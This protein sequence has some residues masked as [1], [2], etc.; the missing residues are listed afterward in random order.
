MT[1]QMVFGTSEGQDFQLLND[2]VAL[3]GTGLT[4]SIEWRDPAPTSPPTV[5]WLSAAAGTVRV[6]GT[7]SM[8]VGRYPFRFKLVDGGTLI[9]YAPNSAGAD[10]W[11]VVAV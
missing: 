10:V 3:N 7:G 11:R 5:A 2:G 6:T 1:H 4:V 9:G 8:A